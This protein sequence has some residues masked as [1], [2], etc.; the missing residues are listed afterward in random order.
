MS[1]DVIGIPDEGDVEDGVLAAYLDGALTDVERVRLESRL[2]RDP[3]LARRL[4]AERAVRA[5]AGTLLDAL[6]LPAGRAAPSDIDHVRARAAGSAR[7]AAAASRARRGPR[8]LPFAWAATVVIAL[9]VGAVWNASRR[10]VRTGPVAAGATG[11]VADSAVVTLTEV[12][13]VPTGAQAAPAEAPATIVA[14]TPPAAARGSDAGGAP[15]ARPSAAAA[16]IVADARAALDAAPDAAANVAQK[17]AAPA[18]APPP[19]RVAELATREGDAARLREGETT[20]RRDVE[21]AALPAPTA[22]MATPMSAPIPAPAPVAGAAAVPAPRTVA[23]RAIDLREA[24]AI[25][26]TTPRTVRDATVVGIVVVDGREWEGARTDRPVVQLGLREPAGRAITV[27]QQRAADDD[28]ADPRLGWRVLGP[29]R[30]RLVGEFTPAT[31]DSLWR[32][33]EP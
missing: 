9:G 13:A 26:G 20:R 30:L 15:T 11:P 27:V 24:A 12:E 33:I 31:V 22:S 7:A 23:R 21:S 4:D 1:R 5:R 29:V 16:P 10:E 6:P 14:A 28:R 25:L 3:A 17:A 19:T 18:A 2:A 32:R 8:L